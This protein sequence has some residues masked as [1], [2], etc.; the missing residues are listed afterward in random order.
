MI[1]QQRNIEKNPFGLWELNDHKKRQHNRLQLIT[2]YFHTCIYF[3]VQRIHYRLLKWIPMAYI[4][5]YLHVYRIIV[6]VINVLSRLIMICF[7]VNI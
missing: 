2:F 4:Y 5:M 7:D 1:E 3:V 6:Q